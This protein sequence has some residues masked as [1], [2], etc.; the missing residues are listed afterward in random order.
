MIAQLSQTYKY[1]KAFI[2]D[3]T[4]KNFDSKKL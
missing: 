4:T 3:D 2:E 1:L